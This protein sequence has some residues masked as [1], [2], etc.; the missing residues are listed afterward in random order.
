MAEVVG[1]EGR[2]ADEA[3]DT[4]LGTE[5]TV[6]VDAGKLVNGGFNTD[7]FAGDAFKAGGFQAG[8]FGVAEIHALEHG[9]PVHGFGAADAGGDAEN[10]VGVV[11]RAGVAEGFVLVGEVGGEGLELGGNLI[12]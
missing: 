5:A 10:G 9:G 11:V 6:G 8:F 3:V 1:V 12:L 4:V 7:F 2:E